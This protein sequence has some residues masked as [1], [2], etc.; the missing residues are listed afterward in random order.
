MENISLQYLKRPTPVEGSEEYQS[1]TFLD[2]DTVTDS[3]GRLLRIQGLSAP[4]IMHTRDDGSLTEAEAGGWEAT[5]QIE[6]IANKLGYNKIEYLTN[7]DGSPMLDATKTRQLIRIKDSRGRDLVESLSSYG[8]GDLGRYS[9]K[10]EIDARLWGEAQVNPNLDPYNDSELNEFQKA[11]IAIEEATQAERLHELRAKKVALNEQELAALRN[12]KRQPGESVAAFNFRQRMAK[13]YSDLL[14]QVRHTDRTLSNKALHPWSE[15][16]DIGWTGA[17]EGMFGAVDMIGE[18]SGFNWLESIGEDGVKRQREYLKTKPDLKMSLL[19]PEL[20]EEGN[21]IGNDWDVEGIGGFFEYVGNM[22]AVSLP[23]MGVTFAGALAAPVTGGTSLAAATG[24]SAL[25][26]VGVSMLAPVSM[27]A[28]QTWN[29]ME[30][31]KKSATLASAAGITMAVLDR[32]GIK[33]LMGLGGTGGTLLKKSTRDQIVK[34]ILKEN[35]DIR[36]IER[37]QGL[38]GRQL[39]PKLT[40]AGARAM[41]AK[42]TRMVAVSYLDDAAKKAKEQLTARNM[43]RALTVRGGLGFGIESTTEVGQELTGYL[44]AVFGSDKQFDAVQLTDRLTNAAIAGGTLGAG[45]SVP[46]TAADVGAWTDVAVRQAP[47]EADRLHQEEQW[48]ESEK[49]K[50]KIQIGT[51]KNGKP[52]YQRDANGKFVYESVQLSIED[53]QKQNVKDQKNRANPKSKIKKSSD[54]SDKED[55]GRREMKNRGV[56]ERT[57]DAF[58]SIPM[59]LKGSMPF[60]FW[61]A[62]FESKAMRKLGSQFNG[63]LHRVHSGESFEEFK[64]LMLAKYRNT[65]QTPAEVAKAAGFGT[66]NPV[67]LSKII[68]DFGRWVGTKKIVKHILD[69]NEF[70]KDKN[71]RFVK[72]KNG[73]KIKNPTYNQMIYSINPNFNWKD[74]PKDVRKHR[75][76]LEKYAMNAARL[77]DMLWNDQKNAREA[78]GKKWDVGHIPN[79]IL[80]YKAF[81]KVAIEKKKNAF[82]DA[83]VKHKKLS[84]EAATKIAND[85]LNNRDIVDSKSLFQVARGLQKPG[86][87]KARKL[88]L[89]DDKNFD[90]FM[91]TDAFVNVSNSAKSATRYIAYQK[92]V[93]DNGE[94]INEYLE[95]ALDEG[96]SEKDVNRMAV[97]MQDYLDAESGNYKRIQ[98]ETWAKIQKNLLVWTT[99]AGLPLATVSSFVEYMMTMRALNS[100]QIEKTFKGSAREFAK[101]A[102][103]TIMN[104]RLSSTQQRIE[105]EN[106][107]QDLKDLGFF[108]WDVGA[109]Q[110]TGATENTYASRYL[111][112]KFFR[113]I[114]LQQWT[115]YTRNIRAAIADDFIR[116]HIET[117]IRQRRSGKIRTNEVQEAESQLSNLG[118][119]VGR[120]I[121]LWDGPNI[122]PGIGVGSEANIKVIQDW[123]QEFEQMMNHAKFNFVNEAIAL[124][125]TANRPLFYQNQHLALFTQFQGFIATFT[126]NHIP[127]M[128]GDYVKRG[129]PAMK[130]NAFAIM[131]TMILLGFV[132]QYLKDLLK[133][134]KTTPYL[135]RMEK[136]QRGIGASGMIG[137]AERPLDFFFPIYETSSKGNIEWFFNTASGEAAALSNVSR[138][139]KGVTQMIAGNTEPGLYKVLKTT[140]V[141]GPFNQFNQKVAS[142]V[143]GFFKNTGEY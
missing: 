67:Q 83:L 126:A 115:D 68:N 117:I 62:A 69:K 92:F 45:F 17:I 20:D 38:K 110:T 56:G 139:A 71:G 96:M 12:P 130:Y 60:T 64:H 1:F 10:N 53:L 77:G 7:P 58:K 51:D 23:Y 104:P 33:G 32:L 63:F 113:I 82:I 47:A 98:N 129:T 79:Y 131:S 22:A 37:S 122:I 86:S 80:R 24:V 100:E 46:G 125:G 55:A 4:E 132:S 72:D 27:Y 25:S 26:G 134:G 106:R 39:T 108:D 16:F 107:Q 119:N 123:T 91:E 105:K 121:T 40:E 111:L 44:A 66:I 5:K 81:D 73:N 142:G 8:I 36:R 52:V 103:S 141:I 50:R 93:G 116:N 29:E 18:K 136:I 88:N 90:E 137:V 76:W 75:A 128:W 9:S 95:Q 109:A 31:D 87:Q 14:V 74:A 118:I 140:P 65:M 85:I 43:L 59:L 143:T 3:Q 42:Q 133:Y 124:P 89:S 102:W 112:D 30:G 35:V 2:A 97:A 94:V 48:R 70:I 13:D 84:R 6:G 15:G 135:D 78:T 34:K 41:L 138:A 120:L 49:V 54:L 19:T 57:S 28:G 99:L 101:A 21:V 127:R 61:K 11:K 114:G